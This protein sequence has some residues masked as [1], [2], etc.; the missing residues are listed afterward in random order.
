ME[1]QQ[2][3][4]KKAAF[5]H[6]IAWFFFASGY[7]V[8]KMITFKTTVP[9]MLFFRGLI[10]TLLLLPV[11]I[12]HGWHSFR[13][14]SPGW[15]VLRCLATTATITLIFLSVRTIPLVD[16]TLL[17][18]SAPF[19]VPFIALALLKKAINHRLW[20]PVAFGFIG[21]ILILHPT[22]DLLKLGA[23]FA[24]GSGIMTALSGIVSRELVGKITTHTLLFYLFFSSLLLSI[25]FVVFYWEFSWDT[26]FPLILIG[27]FI[28]IAQ[29]AF[30][31][32]F[33]Y[34]EASYVAPFGYSCVLFGGLFDWIFFSDFPSLSTWI[35]MIFVIASGSWILWHNRSIV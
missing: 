33:R 2:H 14:S 13:V 9:M 7:L 26:F 10:P 32:S 28:L 24:L 11:M 34:A 25:P 20:L 21:V 15:L 18:N 23:L 35:G 29:W 17:T 1:F 6:I 22:P 27:I 31:R 8:S 30:F 5:F 3:N 19:F 12:H 16:T 4:L